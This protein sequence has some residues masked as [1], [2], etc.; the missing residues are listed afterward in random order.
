MRIVIQLLVERWLASPTHQDLIEAVRFSGALPVYV[1]IGGALFLRP[2]GEV[3]SLEGSSKGEPHVETDPRWRIAAL[4]VGAE[5][6]PELRP[7]LP[8]R[9]SEAKNCEACDG[10]GKIRVGGIG[11]QIH[12]GI[13]YGLGWHAETENPGS[14]SP[15]LPQ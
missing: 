3:L 13:C 1:D 4:V 6:Y 15:P 11:P 7:L 8:A 2:D 5:K 9:P 12:C 14:H 10:S